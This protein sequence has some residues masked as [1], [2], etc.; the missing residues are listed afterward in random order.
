VGFA[1]GGGGGRVPAEWGTRALAALID[2]GIAFVGY[3]VLIILVAILGS[4][5]DALG[6]IVWLI[7]LLAIF[8]YYIWN[9][10][11]MQG[12]SG[13]T[14]GK[15]KMNIRLVADATGQP[16]GPGMA[17]VRWLVAGLISGITCGIGG[18]VDILWPLWDAD[19]K[20][21]TDKILNFSVIQA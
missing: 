12:Q 7:G 5:S 6:G 17:F 16:V 4:V 10:V 21:L 18:L 3:I 19:K 14:I 1:G 13:Q 15:Q 2:G 9:F 8:G 11:V 20:R